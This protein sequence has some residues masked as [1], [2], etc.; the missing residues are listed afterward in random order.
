MNI[1]TKMRSLFF[2][3]FFLFAASF[4][5]AWGAE[6]S[7]DLV[8]LQVLT[9]N[10][11]HGA[12]IES[13]KNPGAAKL[14]SRLLSA[15]A[16]NPDGTLILSA[17]DMFQ[18]TPDS[19]LLYGKTVVDVMNAVPFDAMAIGNHEFD[20]GMD[21]LKQRISQSRFPYLG[22]NLF[23][24]ASG[25]PPASIKPYSIIERKGVKIA[26][27]GLTTPQTAYMTN[28]EVAS[29]LTFE[30]P[31]KTIQRL[32]PELRKL[33]VDLFLV[34]G[35]LASY[36]NPYTGEITD[37]AADLIKNTDGL[38]GVISGHSHQKVA[39]YVNSIPVVQ[40]SY[41]GRGIG[42]IDFVYKRSSKEIIW[43]GVSVQTL[44]FDGLTA[45]PKTKEIVE[46][47]QKE[48]SPV[49]NQLLGN[50]LTDLFHDRESKEVSLLGQWVTD[51]MRQEAQADI[52]FQNA[53]GL[54][55]TIP[56]GAI[57][58]GKIYEVLPFDNTLVTVNLTGAQVLKILEH[59]IASKKIGM[60]QFSGIK[61]QQN[62][63]G[64]LHVTMADGSL[65]ALNKTYKV[66]TN[67][68]MYSGGDEFTM[69][70]EGFDYRDTNIPLRDLLVNYIKKQQLLEV[71]K[72]NRFLYLPPLPAAA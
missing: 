30:N 4:Q 31:D 40:A 12:L 45:D 41:S 67:D 61:V 37:E 69:F 48:I 50:A 59:G 53:G 6:T 10:D 26:V 35:H 20:W 70:K 3:L 29:Q 16:K 72:D 25:Q 66:A 57:T 7:G 14:V 55:V 43:A 24:K 38:H 46:Q 36:T 71:Q 68:F 51:V 9:V 18:G 5:T 39:G 62:A 27:I 2:V 44:P 15:K 21:I 23:M 34:L 13:G 49:K 47:A 1:K 33:K 54:R 63:L 52:A 60:V 42:K 28:M 58:M 8:T 64:H 65:L 32:L 22:A 19:N 56:A 11:F 17:G